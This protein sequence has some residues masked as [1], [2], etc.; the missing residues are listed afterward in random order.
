[1]GLHPH[2][3]RRTSWRSE[4]APAAVGDPLNLIFGV[5]VVLAAVEP[6]PAPVSSPTSAVPRRAGIG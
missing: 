5:L 1:M 2:V 3:A 4:A 6:D